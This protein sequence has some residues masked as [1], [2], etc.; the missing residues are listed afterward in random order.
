MYVEECLT[1]LLPWHQTSEQFTE[2]SQ[3]LKRDEEGRNKAPE[4]IKDEM[5]GN[6]V[7]VAESTS[8]A[9]LLSLGQ[10]ESIAAGGHGTDPVTVDT[11]SHKYELPDLPLPKNA[12]FKYRYDPVVAQVTNLL[13]KDGKLSVAQ[14]VGSSI[15]YFH[16]A[17]L[18]CA[19]SFQEI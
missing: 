14:R 9:N 18:S 17:L 1:D 5:D 12:N 13:M 4:V 8:F 3:I 2:H 11:V 15:L 7:N 10:L 19:D 6:K 16:S